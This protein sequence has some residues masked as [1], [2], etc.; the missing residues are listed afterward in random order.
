MSKTGRNGVLVLLLLVVAALIAFV[1]WRSQ[2]PPELTDFTRG[3][4]QP[5]TAEQQSVDFTHADLTFV[6]HPD[7]RSIDGRSI[8]T[9]TVRRPIAKIQFDLDRELPIRDIAVNGQPLAK[10]RWSNPQGRATVQLPRAFAPGQQ[11]QLAIGY[12]GKPHVAKNAPWD[13]GFVWSKTPAGEPWIAT[14]VE[15]E[16][17]DIFWPC[18]DNSLVEIPTVD[19]HIDVPKGLSAPSNGRLLGITQGKD[20]HTVWNWRAHSPNNYAIALN[21]APYKQLSGTFHSRFGNTIPMDFWYLPG[22]DKQAK[23]LFAQFGPTVATFER[24]IGPYP[25]GDEKIA[26]V[27]TPHLGME[28][29]TINAYGNAYK[30]APEGFDWLFNH[31]FSHEWFGN[32]MTN[33]DWD[34][35]W[36]HEGFGSYM[37]PLFIQAQLGR[38]PYDAWMWKIRATLRNAHP[39]VSGRHQLEDQVYDDKTGPGLDIYNKGAW[40][41]HTLRGLIGDQPFFTSLRRLVYGRPDPRPGN[42]QP[43]FGSTNEFVEIVSQESGRDMR[44]F[45]DVYLRQAHLPRLV[46]TRNGNSLSL[47][48]KTPHGLPFPMPVDVSVD[49]K[50][51]TVPMTGGRGSVALASPQSVYVLDPEWKVLRQDDAID[52]FRDWDKAEKAKTAKKK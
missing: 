39:V 7:S 18:F 51:Q 28:H 12:G 29:Q 37:Q 11:L 38:M 41:L 2:K 6:V 25:W 1:W 32:Q 21:I 48:W 3:T 8:L 46:A 17:C 49:G 45:F 16:G 50:T 22:E 42:F 13:G 4:G 5:L 44:W 31:E 30:P 35:M 19:L 47:Q 52:R 20:G 23:K 26:A 36:L 10:D 43:R 15:G 27:E 9:F 14:A 34:D 33:R 24:L 40:V